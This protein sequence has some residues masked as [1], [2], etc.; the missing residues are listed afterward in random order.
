LEYYIEAIFW[1]TLITKDIN[2]ISFFYFFKK[3][4]WQNCA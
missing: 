1:K 3:S 4:R 2:K